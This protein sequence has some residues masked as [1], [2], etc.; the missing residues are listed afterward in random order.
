MAR[1]PSKMPLLGALLIGLVVAY[2]LI[3]LGLAIIDRP[4]D[5]FSGSVMPLD[6]LLTGARVWPLLARSV[7]LAVCVSLGSVTTGGWLAWIEHRTNAP[8]WWSLLSLMP[9]AM[10]SYLVAATARSALSPGGWLGDMLGT[11]HTTGF[12]MA[13]AVLVVIT[14][15]L[16][17]LIIGAA[18]RRSS[19]AEEEAART[20]GA[21]PARVFW[22]VILPRIRPAIGFSGLIALL[23]AISDF[24]AVAVL[25][26]PVLTWRLYLAVESQDIARAAVLGG[27]TLAAT[28]PL[29][30]AARRIRGQRVGAGTANVR[31]VQRAPATAPQRAITGSI[32]F[33]VVGLGA[34]IPT[35]TLLIWVTDGL[36]RGLTFVNPWGA[37]GDTLL[38]AVAGA[39]L[40]VLLAGLPAFA[41]A[42]RQR[43]GQPPGWLEEGVYA[44]SALPGV[45]LALGLMLTTLWLTG[46]LGPGTYAGVLG[47]GALL[48]LGYATRFI[49]EVFAPLR[50]AF[51]AIDERQIDSAR[52]LGA[53]PLKRLRTV[54]LP[55]V[56]P[57]LA[58]AAMIGFNAIVKELPV[59][60]LLGGA[61][62]LKTL[63]FR[64]WDRYNESLWHDAGVAGL[65]LVALA[66]TSAVFT[67]QWRRNG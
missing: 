47:S 38:A 5:P 45:L 46:W 35:I 43:L 49:A 51:S 57:G 26:V 14:A 64:V 9:M 33:G 11:G 55:A 6:T 37:L 13:V 67:H 50:D 44:S 24:G 20:L 53:R 22:D 29:F 52:A 15:P 42:K 23:Y 56:S 65:L 3:G 25:D 41:I 39:A 62:G 48:M 63:S 59:T 16:S 28:L 17:Q 2:P 12:G 54:V 1:L 34:A 4:A 21:S 19:A 61:T 7:F 40:T 30:L 27:A 60:L 8:R 58:V 32:L 10:P 66:L 18:L 31:R 36:R